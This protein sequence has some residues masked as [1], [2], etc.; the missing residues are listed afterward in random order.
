MVWTNPIYHG[1]VFLRALEVDDLSRTHEWLH[2]ADIHSRIGVRIPFSMETQRA[3]FESLA[4]IPD[5]YVF[6]VCREDNSIHIGNVSIDNIDNYH[7]HG[8]ISIFLADVQNRNRG[9]GSDAL[10]ALTD[11]SF[12][13]LRLHRI[14]CKT[15][16]DESALE[17]FYIRNGFQKEG[18]LVEHEIYN[19]HFIDKWLFGKVNAAGQQLEDRQ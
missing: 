19:G 3:W 16:A 14:W 18:R 12:R 13:I 7:K 2:R 4:T 1:S 11:F 9:F 6:A 10:S 5:K 15:N 8:R 17:R